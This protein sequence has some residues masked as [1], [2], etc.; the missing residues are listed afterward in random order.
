MGIKAPTLLACFNLLHIRVCP[1]FP[2]A[3]AAATQTP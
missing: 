1:N 2:L 3:N